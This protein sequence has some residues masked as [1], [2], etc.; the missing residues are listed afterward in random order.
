MYVLIL[1]RMLVLSI[2]LSIKYL[3][4]FIY[5]RALM[6]SLLLKGRK[7]ACFRTR[8]YYYYY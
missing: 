8:S 5:I 7:L 4:F 3:Y 6:F 2:Q 1:V